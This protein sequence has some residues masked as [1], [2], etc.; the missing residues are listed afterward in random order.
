MESET[1]TNSLY[2]ISAKH[3]TESESF[4]PPQNH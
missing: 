2:N 3:S 1:T 4:I